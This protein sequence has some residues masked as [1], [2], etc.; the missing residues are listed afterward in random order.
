MRHY[1][2]AEL[3]L[4]NEFAQ[5]FS[6][7][8]PEQAGMLNLKEVKDRDPYV[9]R[10]IEGMAFLTAQIRQ[11]IDDD[12]PDICET[13]LNHVK[14]DFLRPYPSTTIVEFYP[15]VGQLQK[16]KILH[17]GQVLLS[18]PVGNDKVVCKFT[19]TSD[20]EL[21][22]IKINDVVLEDVQSGGSLLKL[23][24]KTDPGVSLS[25]LELS[26]LKIHIHDD[27]SIS[28]WILEQ[29]CSELISVKFNFKDHPDYKSPVFSNQDSVTPCNLGPED[30]LKQTEENDFYG[31]NMIQDYFCFRDKYMFFNINK[32]NL[33]SPLPDCEEFTIEIKVKGLVPHDHSISQG[34]FRLFC[35]PAIN[36]FKSQSEP[37]TITNRR[38]SYPVFSDS[39]KYAAINIYNITNVTS[40]DIKSGERSVLLPISKFKHKD[41]INRYFNIVKNT[42]RSVKTDTYIHISGN[43]EYKEEVLSC[44]IQATN[45]AYP[46]QYLQEHSLF[47]PSSDF[48]SYASFYNITRPSNYLRIPDRKYYKWDLI[49][50]LSVNINSLKSVDNI[51]SLLTLYDWSNDKQN[52]KRIDGIKNVKIK[53]KEKI[54]RGA[55]IR[56]LVINLGV[57]ED[58]YRSS[59]DIWLFGLIL[60]NFFSM[61]TSINCFVET[62]IISFPTNKEYKW[63]PL[64]GL[65]TPI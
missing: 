55:L 40:L 44:D 27:P 60:H 35:S 45:G 30:T 31:F 50:N 25:D 57:Q 15:R 58:N 48:P 22:P 56:G 8:Y 24:F 42:F 26:K 17:K 2:E 20:V 7:A 28:L 63:K 11:Q 54:S 14:P 16:N 29:I 37:V 38:T 59:S 53:S 64:I 46:R 18:K 32:L 1:F 12:I 41:V 49:S 62:E 6:E 3:R 36:I 23:I 47:T 52:E 43:G 39:N 51:K 34:S 10:L 33:L 21:L 19:S 65:N 61:Y 9:E 13:F 5:E 4:L